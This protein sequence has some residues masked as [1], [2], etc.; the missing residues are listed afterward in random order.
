MLSLEKTKTQDKNIKKI[1]LKEGKGEERV[2][3]NV[4]EINKTNTV[5]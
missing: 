5:I 4:Q 3:V 1:T 2:K